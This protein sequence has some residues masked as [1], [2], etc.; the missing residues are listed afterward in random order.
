MPR[1]NKQRLSAGLWLAGLAAAAGFALLNTS[2]RNDMTSF[3]PRAATPVQ[4][5]LM[6][7]L[8]EGPVARLTLITLGG[9]PPERLADASKQVAAHLRASGLFVRVT[10]GEQLLDD[11]ERERLFAYRYHLSPAVDADRFSVGS[12]RSA[13][14][15]RLRE[16][17]SPVPAFDRPWLAEDPT[18]ELRAML[19]AWRGQARPRS[20]R[21]V[22]FDAEGRRALLL[23]Q[24]RAPG[25]D[26]DAQS[27]AQGVIRDAVSAAGDDSLELGSSGTG[28]FAVTSR[29][30]IRTDTRRLGIAAALVAI[31]ILLASYRSLRLLLIG[32]LPLMSA[33]VAGTLAVDIVF[34]AIHGI[35]LA[36][37][38]TVIGVAI[39]Y[40]IHLF[41]HLNVGEP[42]R[43]SLASIWPTS[44]LGAIT[45]AM[46][47]LAMSG[48]DFPG[49]L[50]FATFAIAGLLA[51]AAC[52]RWGLTGLLPEVHAARRSSRLADWYARHGRPGT[53]WGWLLIAAA[54]VALA[55]VISRDAA[56]WQ[57]DIAA[58]SPIPASVMARDRHLHAQLG[59]PDTNHM[60]LIEA[61]DAQ[62][63]LEAS[64]VIAADLDGLVADGV[65]TSFDLAA[66]YLP[67]ARTQRQ[68]RDGLP[69][70]AL[71][72]AN[73]DQALAG[74]PFKQGAFAPFEK[75]VAA[76]RTL[77]PLLP[78]DL[79]GSVLGLRVRSS[80]LP[81]DDGW[82]AL[83]TLAGVR[84]ADALA[85]WLD[86]RRASNLHYL[87]LKRD[88]G[89]LMA[90]FRRHAL[91]RVLWGLV[92]I[93]LILW[94][95]LRSLRRTMLVLVPG[96]VAVIIDVAVLR[97]GGQLLSLFHLV[98]LL[99][100]VGISI[101]YSLFFSRDD[102][103]AGM[104]GRTFHGLVV[105]ALSTVS[106]FG[107]LATSEL[108]VLNGIGSS[109]AI[110]VA[111][112]FLAALVLAR[113][114]PAA[115]GASEPA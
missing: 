84:D 48:T 41:S 18:A 21:G 71:L 54:A 24:T 26:L 115:G 45:T 96:L 56:P 111:L 15:K 2:V 108:P 6:N 44:R 57:D 60:L 23:A 46:G 1:V 113:P 80:L 10:N 70:P 89:S 112:S 94:L 51:A 11:A 12:L 67:S 104:R 110:G 95:G 50:Q 37:G 102:T 62:A 98:S 99:L 36:F 27:Q 3:M 87:D 5:L 14:E 69:E 109:V 16:L 31:L 81:V 42:V 59:V 66:R 68:R 13:F 33:V 100:V 22:W 91:G 85:D 103:D 73:L 93:V 19:S 76:A 49:L 105:C 58:L 114:A 52:T 92:A 29:D 9:A 107:I 47:Y 79:E 17:A 64:E 75:A 74:L 82:V 20:Y 25:L 72:G 97:M 32:G 65:I 90:D 53:L 55:W 38:V 86:G 30:I 43:K 8:R 106:V 83:V 34:G 7:E 88:T 40:P 101:D 77:A 78:A 39:D 63:A 35:V 4:R 28:V 61:R